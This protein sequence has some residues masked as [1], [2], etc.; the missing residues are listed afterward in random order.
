MAGPGRPRKIRPE[1]GPAEPRPEG[2]FPMH[3]F[4]GGE[5]IIVHNEEEEAIA[6]AKGFKDSP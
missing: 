1:D 5:Y 6:L 3:L 2:T 4:L